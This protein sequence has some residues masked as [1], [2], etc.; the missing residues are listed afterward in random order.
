MLYV[1]YCF[2]LEL[3]NID[4]G[5]MIVIYVKKYYRID[6]IKVFWWFF[7]LNMCMSFFEVV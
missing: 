2:K 5:I 6:N 1:E 7:Y 4:L 3:I